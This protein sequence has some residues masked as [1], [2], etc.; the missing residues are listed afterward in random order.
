M[1]ELSSCDTYS[2]GGSSI[3]RHPSIDLPPALSLHDIEDFDDT[4]FSESFSA[5]GWIDDTG[6]K[7]DTSYN[8]ERIT[9]IKAVVPEWDDEEVD[10]IIVMSPK[11]YHPLPTILEDA[12]EPGNGTGASLTISDFEIISGHAGNVCR[13][14][15]NG[16][17]F[18]LKRVT[19][20]AVSPP[21]H[22]MILEAVNRLYAP[23]LVKMHWSFA[24]NDSLCMI[25]D[26][27]HA[28]DLL[29]FISSRKQFDPNHA[30]FYACELVEGLSS[31]LSAGI[32]HRALRPENVMIDAEGHIMLTG[33]D[34]AVML[35]EDSDLT[36]H[37][38][39]Y[40]YR[41]PELLLGWSYDFAV[42]CWGFGALFYFILLGQVLFYS[43]VPT[44]C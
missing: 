4:P 26:N 36:S 24:D 7:V 28:G 3:H 18:A 34:D 9:D 1:S 41:A 10:E 21:R 12:D 23:F 35:G 11:E 30:Q 5:S 15:S 32:I 42:D 25:L 8:I 29:T 27:G 22:T 43:F 2:L 19:R 13:R 16:K 6:N 40:E 14:R 44:S 17:V 39:C 38:C 37:Y 33:F 20:Q 31:L